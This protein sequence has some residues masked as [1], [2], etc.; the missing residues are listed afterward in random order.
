MS[1]DCDSTYHVAVAESSIRLAGHLQ[2]GDIL[3]LR[4]D[5]KF[6]VRTDVGRLAAIVVNLEV[7]VYQGIVEIVQQ[8]YRQVLVLA[9]YGHV[10][11]QRSLHTT[12]QQTDR[13]YN[14]H[15]K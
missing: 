14:S 7:R 13:E 2:S 10:Q 6:K 12:H 11:L 3:Q 1:W 4:Q 8:W 5:G 15:W 9:H